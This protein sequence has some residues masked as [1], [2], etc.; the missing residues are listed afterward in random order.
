[1]EDSSMSETTI[2]PD[3]PPYEVATIVELQTIAESVKITV[4]SQAMRNDV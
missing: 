3:V 1:M 2:L 4:T